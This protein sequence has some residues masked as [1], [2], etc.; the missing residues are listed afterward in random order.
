MPL[1]E[2]PFPLSGRPFPLSFHLRAQS[3]PGGH[4]G[5]RNSNDGCRWGCLCCSR[6]SGHRIH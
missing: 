1:S 6:L 2:R 4:P 5:S 3:G